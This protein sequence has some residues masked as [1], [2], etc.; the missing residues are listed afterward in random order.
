[1]FLKFRM[2]KRII[3]VGSPQVLN[4]DFEIFA[5]SV[6]ATMR[7]RLTATDGEQLNQMEWS[8]VVRQLCFNKLLQIII[9][10]IGS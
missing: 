3:L 2:R 4:E 6:K 9:T 10:Q 1:M 5:K 7:L 8:F